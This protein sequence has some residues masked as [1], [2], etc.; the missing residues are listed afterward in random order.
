MHGLTPF[1]ILFVE[2]GTQGGGSF[3]SL[4]QVLQAMDRERFSPVVCFLVRT[5]FV[6]KIEALNIPV[7]VLSDPLYAAP[8]CP[9]R[10]A[11]RSLQRLVERICPQG[12]DAF[13]R[14][15]HAR[16]ARALEQLLRRHKTDLLVLNDQ[17]DRDR[18]ALAAARRT[19]TPVVSHL[20]SAFAPG[21]TAADGRLVS[22]QVTAFIANSRANADF[23]TARGVDAQRVKTVYNPV[24]PPEEPPADLMREFDVPHDAPV[25]ACVGRLTAIKGQDVLIRAAAALSEDF[26]A[27]RVLLIGDGHAR[28]RLQTLVCRCGRAG[29]VIFAGWRQ[30][31]VTLLAAADVLAVPSREEAFGRVAVE[32]MLAGVPV[33]AARTGGLPEIIV[34]GKTGLLVDPGNAQ[35][36]AAALRTLLNDPDHAAALAA[37]ARRA[38]EQRFSIQTV[39]RELETVYADAIQQQQPDTT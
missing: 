35:D 27:L 25:V 17:I 21:F 29:R 8:N 6:Q 4:Y 3:V 7:T 33:V 23:W 1:S 15:V 16:T 31:A 38:A 22:T 32:G 39:V 30:D 14:M 20:R 11:L 28:R 10:L 37:A 2:T 18:F 34:S 12:R 24:P 26:P 9:L 19:E 5:P 36:L 13:D